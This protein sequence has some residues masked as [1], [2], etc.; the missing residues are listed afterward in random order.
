[1]RKLG[2]GISSG[3]HAVDVIEPSGE[4]RRLVIRRYGEHWQRNDPAVAIREWQT[5]TVLGR[6][7]V[8]APRPVWLDAD[9]EIF[10]CPTIVTTRLPG[11]GTLAP[12]DSAG[13]LRQLGETLAAIHRVPLTKSDLG[14]LIE[15]ET[16]LNRT[17][18]DEE[19]KTGEHPDSAAVWS[20]LRHWWPRLDRTAPTLVHGDYWPGNTLWLRGRLTGVVD[21]EQPRFGDPGQDVGC[22]RLD[23]TLLDGPESAERFLRAYEAAS[24][25]TVP[26]LF[27]WDLLVATW[28][29]TDL[30]R[31]LSA[32]HGLGRTDITPKLMR[33]RL[34]G[35]I[36]D[37][38]D[39]AGANA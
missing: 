12:R 9:G 21:W 31:W 16:A 26:Q 38:L 34:R 23:L 30:E 5:L 13:W 7:D 11:R 22:C 33:S 25:R 29:L 39:R 15:Q 17:L 1:M 27:F 20:A 32:Y 2:G 8:P 10:G 37:A 28:G 24:G 3:M 4:R 19:A 36:A 18:A 6:V 14:F 35:F